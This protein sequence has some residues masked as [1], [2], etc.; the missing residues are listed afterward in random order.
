MVRPRSQ[1]LEEL[2]VAKFTKPLK[3]ADARYRRAEA[4]LAEARRVRAEAAR[5]AHTAG[6][7]TW[8]EVGEVLGVSAQRAEALAAD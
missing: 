1:R 8:R 7:L 3:D 5:A 2:G 4:A 6:G